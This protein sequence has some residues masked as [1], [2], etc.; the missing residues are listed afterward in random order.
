M[1]RHDDSRGFFQEIF[2]ID[3]YKDLGVDHTWKQANWSYNR[4]GS[5]RGIHVAPYA[6][7]VTCVSGRI[8]DVVVDLR[9]DS[10]TFGEWIAD[11]LYETKQMYVPPGCGHAFCSLEDDTSVVYLQ[12]D[13][14]QPDKECSVA[15]NDPIL[16][17][18]WPDMGYVISDKDQNAMS[19]DA[20]CL[21]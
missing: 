2:Q 6:K 3:R 11:W 16:R 9:K 12:S 18:S 21:A 1:Q 10:P 7:L 13:V 15:W 19:Y 20:Y 5:L 14:Y 8:W 17:I 4:L